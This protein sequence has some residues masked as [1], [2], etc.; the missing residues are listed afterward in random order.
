MRSVKIQAMSKNKL[1]ITG[2]SLPAKARGGSIALL[3]QALADLSDLYSQSKQALWNVRGRNF[4]MLHELFDKLAGMV[5]GQLDDLAERATA[6]GGVAQGTVRMAARASQL[7]EWPVR[8]GDQDAFAAALTERFKVAANSIREAIDSAAQLGDA[9]TA[10][11]LTAVS[12]EL[13]K[14]LWFL[15]ASK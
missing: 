5:E 6:L 4:F 12:R 1:H 3:N 10:D 14:A 8:P 2:N 11:L 13:D 9:G 7:P 15:E